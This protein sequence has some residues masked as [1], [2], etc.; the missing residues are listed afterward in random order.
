MQTILVDEEFATLQQ[1]LE[2]LRNENFQLRSA[3]RERDLALQ[4][5]T[6][7]QH[8]ISMVEHERDYVRLE[9]N[10]ANKELQELQELRDWKRSRLAIC[11]I[12]HE[13][14]SALSKL[15]L[16]TSRE[17]IPYSAARHGGDP[18]TTLISIKQWNKAI[19]GAEENTNCIN[20]ALKPLEEI[21]TVTRARVDCNDGLKHYHVE[22]NEQHLRAP[23][24]INP[25]EPRPNNGG[26]KRCPFCKRYCKSKKTVTVTYE[27]ANCGI[28]YDRD[29]QPIDHT[30]V[31]PAPAPEP[32]VVE[33]IPQLELPAI[34]TFPRCQHWKCAT[35]PQR[36]EKRAL[37]LY[38]TGHNGY[39]N[40]RGITA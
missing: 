13:R 6:E 21:G 9:L 17:Q 30:V 32:E 8:Q 40:E 39:I 11:A 16:I 3:E 22:I 5:V 31:L 19:G 20:R 37:G 26:D 1:E 29:M 12:P 33:K 38:C 36:I 14:L 7:L 18:A 23:R 35:G 10:R 2:A 15:A 34:I 4:A 28:D 24:L 27:C 25:Q